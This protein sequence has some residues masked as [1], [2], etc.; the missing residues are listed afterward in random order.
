M[1]R[2][3]IAS[4]N[5]WFQSYMEKDRIISLIVHIRK[6]DF[7]IICL[8]EVKPHVYE[9]LKD[10]LPQYKYYYP[11][12]MDVSYGCVILSKHN[13]TE[14]LRI[15]LPSIMERELV[16]ANIAIPNDNAYTNLVIVTTHF[17][18]EFKRKN[19]LK[20]K[21]YKVTHDVLNRLYDKYHNVVL[22][23]DTNI[24]KNEEKMFIPT[25]EDWSDGWKLKGNKYNE[26]TYDS[27]KNP[28]V[29]IKSHI[30]K[31][32]SR[33]D[34]ILYKTDKYNIEHFDIIKIM[35]NYIEPSDHY[36]IYGVFDV[37]T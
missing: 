17:E 18:S 12:V 29:V 21:Q 28:H 9:V 24:M 4:Y 13:I 3:K 19:K 14:C 34:R 15:Q 22:C 6:Y 25:N 35:D 31:I 16:I 27:L 7:D 11:K 20:I 2:L 1:N 37:V 33:L 8:Q 10:N 30:K 5:I 23:A 36:G 32:K 26:Y